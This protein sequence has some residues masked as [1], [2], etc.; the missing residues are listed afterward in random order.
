MGYGARQ[1]NQKGNVAVYI[2]DGDDVIAGFHTREKNAEAFAH[3]RRKD[4]E[5]YLGRDLAY[6][7]LPL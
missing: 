3:A 1:L 5:D 6:S 2:L 7:V 4:Y